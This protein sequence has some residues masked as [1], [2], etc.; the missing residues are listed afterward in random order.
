MH[1]ERT[2]CEGRSYPR[3]ESSCHKTRNAKDGQ[4]PPETYGAAFLTASEETNPANALISD[5]RLPEL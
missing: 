1:T 3:E 2:P 4:K 5:L